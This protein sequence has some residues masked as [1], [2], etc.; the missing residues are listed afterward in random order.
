M[1]DRPYTILSCAMSLDG[2]LDDTADRRL[3][4]SNSADFDR[5]DALRATCDAILVGATTVR[6]D[7]PHLCVRAA[8][9]RDE[10]AALGLPPS[11]TKVTV[12]RTAQLAQTSNFFT[13][14]EACKLVYCASPAVAQTRNRLGSLATIIDGGQE[15]DMTWLSRDLHARGIHRLLVEGGRAI[16]TQFLTA[17]LV[18]EMQLVVAP[19][20]VG[21]NRAQRFV[22]DGKFPWNPERRAPLVEARAIDDVVLLR[23]ALSERFQTT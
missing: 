5:V 13:A 9:R 1:A 11:P 15:V 23:Y 16:Y 17:D 21:D 12:S 2:Y 14:G 7:N 4:L 10:R 18:D 3:L 19:L 6:K 20:F 8:A 22:D